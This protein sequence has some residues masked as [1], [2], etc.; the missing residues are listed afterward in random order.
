MKRPSLREAAKLLES[1]NSAFGEA[2]DATISAT[3]LLSAPA[4]KGLSLSLFDPKND[5]IKFLNS[6]RAALRRKL[7]GVNQYQ[8]SQ[9]VAAAHAV[10]VSGAFFDEVASIPELGKTQLTQREISRIN[11]G[12]RDEEARKSLIGDY[13]RGRLPAPDISIPYSKF[14]MALLTHYREMGERLLGT[15]ADL[16]VWDVIGE[17]R[18]YSISQYIR[19][20]VHHKAF[21]RYEGYLLELGRDAPEVLLWT[22]LHQHAAT[23]QQGK[24]QHDETT[25]TLRAIQGMLSD[26]RI[27]LLS[28]Q[29]FL[30]QLS[31]TPRAEADWNRLAKRYTDSFDERLIDA[32]E[33][34]VP[35]DVTI[36]ALSEIYIPPAFRVVRN[37]THVRA[38]ENVWWESTTWP[39][40][41]LEEFIA[42]Y[43][44]SEEA[45]EGPL[46]VLGH[47]GA[48]KSVLM[49]AVASRLSAGGYRVVRVDLRSVPADA[50]I[51][52][53]LEKAMRDALSRSVDWADMA[54][55]AGESTPV[56]LLDGFDELLQASATSR[57]DYI[58]QIK[59]FQRFEALRGKPLIA[60]VTSRTVVANRARIPHGSLIVRLEPFD[61]SRIELWVEAWQ[62]HNREYMKAHPERILTNDAALAYKH[63]TEQPLLLL[64]LAIYVADG[65]ALPAVSQ[66]T[67][68]GLGTADMYER[69]LVAFAR[70]EALRRYAN[71]SE[72]ELRRPIEVELERLAIAAFAMFNR[73]AQYVSESNLDADLTLLSSSSNQPSHADPVQSPTP[74]QSLVGRFFFVHVARSSYGSELPQEARTYEFLHATFGEYLIARIVAKM[75]ESI[76]RLLE[77]Q[78]SAPMAMGGENSNG[79]FSALL[80]FQVLA[81]RQQIIDFLRETFARQSESE[82]AAQTELLLSLF[83]RSL[84]QLPEDDFA[85]YLP[86]QLD[87]PTRL[88]C[89]SANV[90][91]LLCAQG[92]IAVSSL[93]GEDDDSIDRWSQLAKMWQSR[94]SVEAW[95]SLRECLSVS[96]NDRDSSIAL[97]RP[98]VETGALGGKIESII[99]TNAVVADRAWEML[100]NSVAPITRFGDTLF[101]GKT[102]GLTPARHLL[103]LATTSASSSDFYDSEGD[104]LDGLA[105]LERYIDAIEA[106]KSLSWQQ[107]ESDRYLSWILKLYLSDTDRIADLP[108]STLRVL[109]IGK[110]LAVGAFST[111]YLIEVGVVR[112]D[113]NHSSFPHIQSV[114]FELA[115]RLEASSLTVSR[116]IQVSLMLTGHFTRAGISR[117]LRPES[118]LNELPKIAGELNNAELIREVY[119]AARIWR[120]YTWAGNTGF[121]TLRGLPDEVLVRID[122]QD[123]R[124]VLS[125]ATGQVPLG[126][127]N[128][129]RTR[130]NKARERLGYAASVWGGQSG[131][132]SH[133][134]SGSSSRRHQPR[135]D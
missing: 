114:V 101:R 47:P 24:E 98:G 23:Q 99:R 110:P 68:A 31:P 33:H 45:V 28:V 131:S 122:Q 41:D 63:I 100:L 40:E 70:R 94:L 109:E 52:T 135:D 74:A 123:L 10:A 121:N 118:A 61:Q 54:D 11:T 15:L 53:Q 19:S 66:S 86:T 108:A 44:T 115:D 80:S 102:A 59:E 132:A 13:A 84:W 77:F 78:R 42:A 4:T 7:T 14:R 125:S 71:I 64:M 91:I 93:L 55:A 48:G 8:R 12:A 103:S 32:N 29:S 38:S 17:S 2:L 127:I 30:K 106:T 18:Q 130:W 79:H 27:G 69:I 81:Q 67:A 36:P 97:R 92:P 65:N 57:Y 50:P 83:K 133:S 117:Q 129:I 134:S 72:D 22:N 35:P 9:L 1:D 73:N 111:S 56:V 62:H 85:R 107:P 37:D 113:P 88:T 49:R 26:T 75:L 82:L 128:D 3:L 90:T 104:R 43:V 112:S 124:Y 116:R 60:V 51:L 6:C 16:C 76:V 105:R 46:V 96:I 95:A 126:K 25:I 5:L 87:I 89:Y 120:L 119:A 21:T 34:V 39:R 58:E 20:E